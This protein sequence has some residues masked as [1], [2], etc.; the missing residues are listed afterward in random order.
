M[1]SSFRLGRLR[2]FIL[3]LVIILITLTLLLLWSP[4]YSIMYE[5]YN[6]FAGYYYI[7]EINKDGSFNVTESLSQG[8][9]THEHTGQLSEKEVEFLANYIIMRDNYFFLLDRD[10]SNHEV[11]DGTTETLKI[12]WGFI[13]W[14]SGGYNVGNQT[15]RNII[16]RIEGTVDKSLQKQ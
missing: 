7:L 14:V 16:D 4:N 13:P 8:K 2:I 6:G 10:L 5:K 12:E 1:K 9:E 15:L 11:T 3:L